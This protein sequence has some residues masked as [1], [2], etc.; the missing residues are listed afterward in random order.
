MYFCRLY[1]VDASG[2]INLKEIT[3]IMETM[4]QVEG[5]GDILVQD[6]SGGLKTVAKR[7]DEIFG[8]LDVDHDGEITMDEF[9]EGYLRIH[10]LDTR[11]GPPEKSQGTKKPLGAIGK[12]Q[13]SSGSLLRRS[14]N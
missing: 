5:R 6:S 10:S 11:S 3:T 8:M 9:V 1:D 13:P 7:A 12:R 14:Q 4:D 2:S